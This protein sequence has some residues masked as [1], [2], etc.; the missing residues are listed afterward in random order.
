MQKCSYRFA[1]N[2]LREY[3][4]TTQP[5]AVLSIAS[6]WNWT[7]RIPILLPPQACAAKSKITN[8]SLVQYIGIVVRRNTRAPLTE[9]ESNVFILV[10]TFYRYTCYLQPTKRRSEK[11]KKQIRNRKGKTNSRVNENREK[12]SK[13][14]FLFFFVISFSLFLFL[15]HIHCASAVLSFSLLK[16]A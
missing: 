5:N 8:T 1:W 2:K 4:Y 11:K 7:P 3:T 16:I 14:L 6:T 13:G 15:F 12:Y 9:V 10:C